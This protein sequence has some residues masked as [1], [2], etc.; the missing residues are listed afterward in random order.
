MNRSMARQPMRPLVSNPW[1]RRHDSSRTLVRRTVGNPGRSYRAIALW[2]GSD[3]GL[4]SRRPRVCAFA[5]GDVA[6][7][8]PSPRSPATSAHRS[9][10]ALS[11]RR[12][13][14]AGDGVSFRTRCQRFARVRQGSGSC[15]PGPANDALSIDIGLPRECPGPFRPEPDR[16]RCNGAPRDAAWPDRRVSRDASGSGCPTRSVRPVSSDVRR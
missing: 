7:P 12:L 16:A 1:R 8:A 10:C 5:L 13:A 11:R 4:A 2:H 3:A 15:S 14:M 9:S 6:R